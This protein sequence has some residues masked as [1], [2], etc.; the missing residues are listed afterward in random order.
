LTGWLQLAIIVIIVRY[1]GGGMP[2]KMALFAGKKS[3]NGLKMKGIFFIWRGL[4][5]GLF[6]FFN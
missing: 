6:L 4:K 2:L 5:T 1:S 3:G